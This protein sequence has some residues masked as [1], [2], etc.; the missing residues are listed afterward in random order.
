MQCTLTTAALNKTLSAVA[1]LISSRPTL[2]ILA[3]ISF[4][5]KGSLA[6]FAVTD[7]YLGAI[8]L[9]GVDKCQEGHC[10]I[11]GKRFAEICSV[12]PPGEVVFQLVDQTLH[13]KAKS[14]TATLQTQED[15]D[16]P[17]FPTLS[18][19]QRTF[20]TSFVQ[21]I[22]QLASIAAS[23]D[24]ARPMLTG[25]C[26]ETEELQNA[27]VTTDGFRLAHLVPEV[28]EQCFSQQLIIPSRFWS[29]VSRLCKLTSV[30]KIEV[31]YDPTQ[32][33][34]QATIDSIQLSSRTLNG[35]YPPYEKIMPSSFTTRLELLAEELEEQLRRNLV[36]A[37]DSMGTIQ[38][39]ITSK[40]VVVSSQSTSYGKTT[41][42]ITNF[43]ISGPSTTIAFNSR[44][45]LEFLQA[46]KTGK[47]YLET[48]E[49]LKPARLTCEKYPHFQY[50]V[51]PFRISN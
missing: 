50:I 22:V 44:Y 29:E 1:P 37:R 51:M 28:N 20:S 33:Q 5:I 16:Y 34:V 3:N 47:I 40:S 21:N 24:L 9:I 43:S 7:M 25:V 36:Y 19:E 2:P 30:Q 45:V 15:T 23:P 18:G 27:I 17:A 46:V 38:L 14:F 6:S 26:M 42:S 39:E 10:C 48:N 12:L 41:A 31:L 13:I 35:E 8:D 49:P 32:Q 4:L 11:P